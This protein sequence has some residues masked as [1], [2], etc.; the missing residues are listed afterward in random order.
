MIQEVDVI[1]LHFRT[2]N[3]AWDFHCV[4][5]CIADIRADMARSVEIRNPNN[6]L[7]GEFS[8]LPNS[9]NSAVFMY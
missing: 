2:D 9:I 1:G 6:I 4:E 5:I 3:C 8:L 7:T